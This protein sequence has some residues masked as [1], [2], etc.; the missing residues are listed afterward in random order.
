MKFTLTSCCIALAFMAFATDA[1][2]S[3]KKVTVPLIRNKN[4]KANASNAGQKV[5]AKYQSRRSVNTTVASTDS[6][7]T[8]PMTDYYNDVEYYGELTVGTPGVTLKL[9]FDTGSS[10]MWFGKKKF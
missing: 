5:T 2:P 9:D 4:F 3:G 1:A 8:V 10:D 6:N 7:G